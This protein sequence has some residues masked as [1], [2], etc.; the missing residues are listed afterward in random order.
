MGLDMEAR[1]AIANAAITTA[2]RL[3]DMGAH[4]ESSPQERIALLM[5]EVGWRHFAQAIV[6]PTTTDG[7]AEG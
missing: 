2:G 6:A 5:A 1:A 7:E 3:K 4:P